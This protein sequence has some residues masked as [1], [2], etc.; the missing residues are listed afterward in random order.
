MFRADALLPQ[1]GGKRQCQ[2]NNQ[3]HEPTGPTAE[4]SLTPWVGRRNYL[5]WKPGSWTLNITGPTWRALQLKN[6]PMW[7]LHALSGF[8][9]GTAFPA[10]E[11][12][13]KTSFL[14]WHSS[15]PPQLRHDIGRLQIFQQFRTKILSPTSTW[16]QKIPCKQW[17][18]IALQRRFSK[19]W[20]LHSCFMKDKKPKHFYAHGSVFKAVTKKGRIKRRT[21]PL[22][23][24]FQVPVVS[25]THH[26]MHFEGAFKMQKSKLVLD[27]SGTASPAALKFKKSLCKSKSKKNFPFRFKTKIALIKQLKNF[28][29]QV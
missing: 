3:G 17:D 20:I 9:I 6:A 26:K 2:E 11:V 29:N 19:F 25:H 24:V 13:W 8:F 5:T 16:W 22:W 4:Q 14:S 18:G 28:K 10:T 15:N 21:Y 7:L 12:Y 23:M 1:H 27:H